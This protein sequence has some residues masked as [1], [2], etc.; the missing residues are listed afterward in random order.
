M[1]SWLTAVMMLWRVDEPKSGNSKIYSDTRLEWIIL[2]ERAAASKVCRRVSGHF[3]SQFCH[4]SQKLR[5]FILTVGNLQN[6]FLE[7]D[8]YLIT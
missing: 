3:Y 7:Q 8:L 2:K 4:I 6:I 1:L 5:F